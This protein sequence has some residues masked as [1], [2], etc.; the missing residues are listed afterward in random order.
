[1]F[2]QFR[3][4]VAPTFT[5]P[6]EDWLCHNGNVHYARNRCD[7][8]SYQA[9]DPAQNP[10]LVRLQGGECDIPVLG[11]GTVRLHLKKT[12]DSEEMTCI[13]LSGVYHI[14]SAMCNGIALSGLKQAN[15]IFDQRPGARFCFVGGAT[16]GDV[17]CGNQGSGR[18]RIYP[19]RDKE[20][21]EGY[22]HFTVGKNIDFLAEPTY[23]TTEIHHPTKE[24]IRRSIHIPASPDTLSC[25]HCIHEAPCVTDHDKHMRGQ[26]PM[27]SVQ[28][29]TI[30]NDMTIR[31]TFEAY[32]RDPERL[33]H[34]EQ[35]KRDREE[36]RE[37]VRAAD[38]RRK[39][40][41][42]ESGKASSHQDRA[43]GIF[44]DDWLFHNGNVHY[45]RDRKSFVSF[46]RIGGVAH[47][48]KNP[49]TDI[50]IKGIGTVQLKVK[51]QPGQGQDDYQQIL[52][53]NTLWI[54]EASCNGISFALLELRGYE[55]S[56]LDA[57]M[58][59]CIIP[60]DQTAS[61][62]CATASSG[63]TRLLFSHEHDRV[64]DPNNLLIGGGRSIDIS[65]DAESL[66][67]KDDHGAKMRFAGVLM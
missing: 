23:L 60:H 35:Q 43:G 16:G 49:R 55:L 20:D 11:I 29:T 14:P 53:V 28:R 61:V 63:H 15:L 6:E 31:E 65:A 39:L 32:R 4:W 59:R 66:P 18:M 1:M 67:W 25:R 58:R 33:A 50:R 26:V 57:H 21:P 46:K 10:V 42:E 41:V 54:P 19:A 51:R 17:L 24:E 2:G 7:F 36:D 48:M 38:K 30:D 34:R 5:S 56:P 64:K 12:L 8:E 47:V 45:T 27:P 52:L 9:I 40:D 62:A 44:C 13:T 3:E 22:H 37:S